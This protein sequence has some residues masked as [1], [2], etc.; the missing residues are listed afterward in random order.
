M[1]ADWKQ[2]ARDFSDFNEAKQAALRRVLSQCG[3]DTD[4]PLAKPYDLE[5]ENFNYFALCVR[6]GAALSTALNQS[7]A[8]RSAVLGW[9]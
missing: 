1:E 4:Y 6:N 9:E 7:H 3:K 5:H 8:V 2:L